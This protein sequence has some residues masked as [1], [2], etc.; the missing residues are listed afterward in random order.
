MKNRPNRSTNLCVLGAC[1]ILVTL[2]LSGCGAKQAYP[3][4]RRPADQTAELRINPPQAQVGFQLLAVN[5]RPFNAEIDASILPGPTKLSFKVWPTSNT[6]FQ[7]SGPEFAEHYQMIDEKFEQTM[8]ITF[9]AEAG[10][11]YGLNGSFDGDTG[12]SGGT[13]NV[14]VF[15]IG[16]DNK[17]IAQISSTSPAQAADETMNRLQETDQEQW[18]V[19]AGPG[20]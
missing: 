14:T 16:N 18:S 20:S 17:V 8:H 5:D 6:V 1:T 10:M 13:Y 9:N 11:T 19:E 3:G 4:A 15:E 2:L 7:M 12:G